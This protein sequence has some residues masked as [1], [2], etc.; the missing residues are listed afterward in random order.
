M[1]SFATK[2]KKDQHPVRAVAVGERF[3]ALLEDPTQTIEDRHTKQTRRLKGG[4][5]AVLCPTHDMLAKYAEVLRA[6][7]HRVRL[8][9]DGWYASRAVQ[10][11]LHALA[12]LANPARSACGAVSRGHG[13]RVAHAA[14]G[15]RAADGSRADRGAAAREARS[16]GRRGG[17]ADRVHAGGGGDR[18]ARAVRYR[19]ALAGRRAAAREPAAAARP[20]RREF[21][22]A[23]REA[24]AYGG[25]HG[26]GV[27]T[28]LAWL[29]ARVELKDGDRQPEPR[30]L[31]E[32]A[33][34]LT[35][36]HSAKGREWPVVAVCGLDKRSR[37][38]CRTWGSGYASFE[39]LS[40]LLERGADRV[41]AEVRGAGDRRQVPR[42]AR[43]ARARP[44]RGGCCTWR[45]RAR[46][47]SWCSSGRSISPAARRTT[48][49]SLLTGRAGRWRCVKNELDGGR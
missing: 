39:D 41:R 33:I 17:G 8:Q 34:V 38:S 30:V 47:T 25:F 43:C 3:R 45:S 24:L 21:M 37:A 40:R 18:G 12:Y 31:D 26:S 29:E 10:I 32:D 11:A 23:N 22:D 16:A 14:G 27:Q 7:G 35:T 28:F 20:R 46:A 49:W 48:Y 6:Q 36:W 4:D 1:V 15:A 9:A 19:D 5:I 44:R 13:A 42:R 2:A